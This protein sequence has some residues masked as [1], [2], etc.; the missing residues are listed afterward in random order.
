MKIS[1]IPPRYINGLLSPNNAAN[2]GKY[3]TNKINFASQKA[4]NPDKIINCAPKRK[5]IKQTADIVDVQF[6]DIKFNNP[7]E[8]RKD[9]PFNKNNFENN[10]D[11][12]ESR[13]NEIKKSINEFEKNLHDDIKKIEILYNKITKIQL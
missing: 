8:T 13:L 2:S 11:D 5:I 7:A 1:S 4:L 3:K 10:L 9:K 12:L 6:E